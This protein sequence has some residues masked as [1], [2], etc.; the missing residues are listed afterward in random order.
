MRTEERWEEDGEEGR[1][2]RKVGGDLEGER[3][4]MVLF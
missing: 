4:V 1:R 3:E 2:L